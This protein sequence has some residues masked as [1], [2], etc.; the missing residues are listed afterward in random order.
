MVVNDLL[1]L[2]CPD[3]IE[4]IHVVILG[5]AAP[6]SGAHYQQDHHRAGRDYGLES[7]V[8]EL[9]HGRST[10]SVHRVL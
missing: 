8:P 9:N 10:I 5:A 2:A 4:T 6:R 3:V 1:V 7:I